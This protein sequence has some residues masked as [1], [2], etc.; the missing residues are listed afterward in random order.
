[1]YNNFVFLNSSIYYTYFILY[2]SVKKSISDLD[3]LE[4]DPGI[5]YN[6]D[7]S[8]DLDNLEL[9][10][11]IFYNADPSP[12]LSSAIKIQTWI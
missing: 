7:P 12:D 9:D 8:P 10:P 2:K 6:A 4:L 11:G 5:F 1:M 3:N